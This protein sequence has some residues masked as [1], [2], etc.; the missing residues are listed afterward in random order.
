MRTT[1]PDPEPFRALGEKVTK[2]TPAPASP[3]PKP[4][5]PYGVTTGADGRLSTTTH[6]KD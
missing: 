1:D 6:P 4:A 3:S 2:P 5:G